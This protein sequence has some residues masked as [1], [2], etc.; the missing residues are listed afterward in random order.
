[1]T[2]SGELYPGNVFEF[3]KKSQDKHLPVGES[4]PVEMRWVIVKSS[5]RAQAWN[6]SSASD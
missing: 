3:M 5:G 2:A 6:C 1:M 4:Q